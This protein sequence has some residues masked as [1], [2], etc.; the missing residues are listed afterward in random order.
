MQ[1]VCGRAG[2][3]CGLAVAVVTYERVVVC[4]ES[5]WCADRYVRGHTHFCFHNTCNVGRVAAVGYV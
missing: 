3:V 1:Q 4:G 2:C 5:V